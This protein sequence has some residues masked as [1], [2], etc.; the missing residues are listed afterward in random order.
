NHHCMVSLA[1]GEDPALP[2]REGPYAMAAKW[3][4]RWFADGV[5]H[6]APVDEEIERIEREIPGVRID[7]VPEEGQRLS[8]LEQQDS[9]SFELAHIFTGGDSEEDLREK[10]DRCVAALNPL[11]DAGAPGARRERRPDRKTREREPHG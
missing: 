1:L 2:Y 3:Y 5:V 4:Y 10:Y 6:D 11:F 9:Y 7:V 8:Q